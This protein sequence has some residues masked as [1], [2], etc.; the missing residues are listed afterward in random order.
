VRALRIALDTDLEATIRALESARSFVRGGHG[1][2]TFA[3]R[4]Q[5]MVGAQTAWSTLGLATPEGASS[6][7]PTIRA[8][9]Q[10]VG[11]D[12]ETVTRWC[13]RRRPGCP[14]SCAA[15]GAYLTFVAVP[16]VRDGRRRPRAVPPASIM[17]RGSPSCAATRSPSARR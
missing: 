7:T 16:V 11:I 17:P 13:R 10:D 12:R 9:T 14:I 3:A 5:R 8:V 2:R 1:R 15:G 6:R 4:I